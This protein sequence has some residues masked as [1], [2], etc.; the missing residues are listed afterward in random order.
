M[1]GEQDIKKSK[2]NEAALKM[3]RVHKLQDTI[4]ICSVDK[5]GYFIDINK[6][7]IISMGKRNYEVIYECLN[8]LLMEV[9]G[10][11]DENER[12]K[13]MSSRN[14]IGEFLRTKNPYAIQVSLNG[15]TTDVLN[16]GNWIVLEEE[17]IKYEGD[18]RKLLEVHEV[19]G[20]NQ[21]DDEGL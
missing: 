17:L 11:L 16:L 12:K 10:K 19:S 2:F 15:K 3:T 4:N 8:Q 18:V 21:D 7:G 9:W 14:I 5:M 6:I 1:E 13:V 20:N